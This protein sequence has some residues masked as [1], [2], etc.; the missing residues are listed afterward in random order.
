M[1]S[2]LFTSELDMVS[3]NIEL[4]SRLRYTGS[5]GIV[6]TSGRNAEFAASMLSPCQ[7]MTARSSS[8]DGC[9]TACQHAWSKSIRMT[10]VTEGLGHYCHSMQDFLC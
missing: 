9:S 10:D 4:P 7:S 6:A 3:C 5:R 8:T 1:P 2:N